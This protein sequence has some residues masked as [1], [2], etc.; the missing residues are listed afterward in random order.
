MVILWIYSI[1]ETLRRRGLRSARRLG[2]DLHLTARGAPGAVG[3]YLGD[4]K[5][6]LSARD[7]AVRAALTLNEAAARK[8]EDERR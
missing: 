1:I 3:K 5:I 2:S 7:K 4:A 6:E 8:G